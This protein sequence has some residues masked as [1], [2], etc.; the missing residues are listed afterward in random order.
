MVGHNF[1]TG[2]G[3]TISSLIQRTAFTPQELRIWHS[4][5]KLSNKQES[6][7]TQKY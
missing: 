5:E 4:V 7:V 3:A 6:K 1:K 2:H